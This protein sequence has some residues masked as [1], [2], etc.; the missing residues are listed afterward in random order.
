LDKVLKGRRVCSLQILQIFHR[1]VYP[2]STI[3]ARNLTKKNRKRGGPDD[4]GG[5]TDEPMASPKTTRP[6]RLSLGCCTKR[7]F[8]TSP[9]DSGELNANKSG[10]WIKTD[11]D[12]ECSKVFFY[13]SFNVIF[14]GAC[15]YPTIILATT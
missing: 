9:G 6:R 8:S 12:C 3:L 14:A 13:S 11:A 2:E 1:K 5:A 10:H 15:S 7:S 4:G